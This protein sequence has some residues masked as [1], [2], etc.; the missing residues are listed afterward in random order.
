VLG[1][2]YN[3]GNP[4]PPHIGLSEFV[5]NSGSSGISVFIKSVAWI[6][7]YFEE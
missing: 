1:Y 2:T 6:R 7:A 4:V 3:W 5:I